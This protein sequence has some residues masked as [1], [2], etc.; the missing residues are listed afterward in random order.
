MAS[1][2][3]NSGEY[4]HGDYLMASLDGIEVLD[5]ALSITEHPNGSVEYFICHND[6]SRN[7]SKAYDMIGYEFSWKFNPG[8]TSLTDGVVIKGRLDKPRIE[9]IDAKI[10]DR[11]VEFFKLGGYYNI[12]KYLGCK[13]DYL[14]EYDKFDVS[15]TDGFIKLT[16][17]KTNRYIDLK[18][19]RFIKKVFQLMEQVDSRLKKSERDVEIMHNNFVSFVK[20]EQ[21]DYELLKG[22]DILKAYNVTNYHEMAS[23]IGNSCMNNQFTFLELYTKNPDQI[24]VLIL[25]VFGKIAARC[26]VWT[27]I[28]GNKLPNFCINTESFW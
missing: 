1:L 13:N 5:C 18:F 25:K 8:N 20:N 28:D 10:D 17:T 15:S 11:I 2:I 26:L 27:D 22:E 9:L 19:G 3:T 6:S 14:G 16:N 21:H 23:C 12:I 24:S 4:L 7:G